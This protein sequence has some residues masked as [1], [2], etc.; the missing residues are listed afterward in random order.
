MSGKQLEDRVFRGSRDRERGGGRVTFGGEPLPLC[1]DLRRH[2]PTG[3]EWGYHG[4]GPT[5]L[6]LAM[7]I[8][9]TDEAEARSAYQDFKRACVSRIAADRWELP[10]SSV[11][12]WLERRRSDGS[13]GSGHLAVT[14]TMRTI[15]A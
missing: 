6:A 3:F 13:D 1:L 11:S 2:S 10:A 12:R 4:S 7:L 14:E 9:C 15:G 8:A 5:Q